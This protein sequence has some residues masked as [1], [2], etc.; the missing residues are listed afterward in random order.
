MDIAWVV[1]AGGQGSR[2]GGSDK[3]LIEIEENHPMIRN[4]TEKLFLH[5]TEVYINTNSA[6][7]EYEQYAPTFDDILKDRPGP[8]AGMHAAFHTLPHQWIGFV[9]CDVPGFPI[10]VL[11]KLELKAEEN[12]VVSVSVLGR[13]QPV[14]CVMHRQIGEKIHRYLQ[15]GERRVFKF[16]KQHTLTL[17]DLPADGFENINTPLDLNQYRA[18]QGIASIS[19]N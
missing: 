5:S 14:F 3:G 4:I 9:P 6:F 17:V 10:E 19:K 18:V 8:L 11:D 2:M 15:L 13:I 16:L 7:T 12:M 1:L